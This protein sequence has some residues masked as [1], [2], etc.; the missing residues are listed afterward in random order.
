ME[1][2]NRQLISVII[3]AYNVAPW[4]SRCLDSVAAQTYPYLEIIVVDDGSTDDTPQILDDLAPGCRC[5]RVIHTENQGVTKAR[6]TGVRAAKGA[7][8]G[9]VDGDD[10]I[11]PDM[12]ER[13]MANAQ[14]CHA[15]ISHCGYQ[16]RFPDG[17]IRYYH[18]T[19]VCLQMKRNEALSELLDG[20][21][22]EPGLW[23][24][25]FSR[26]L[27]DNLL[28]GKQ[29]DT[30]VRINEDLLMNYYLFLASKR[31][32][33]DDVCK[34]HYM[35]RQG[36]ASRAR[37]N[38][39]RIMD[40]IRVK[41]IILAQCPQELKDTAMRVY[42]RTCVYSYN[43][44][45]W[46]REYAYLRDRIRGM[47]TERKESFGYLP[48]KQRLMAEMIARAPGV[49]ALIYPIYEKFLQRKKYE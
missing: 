30:S 1:E 29:M 45:L 8:I 6:L 17:R 28:T 47:L 24:K 16:T 9:F 33:F 46:S 5:L 23:N 48:K 36:S 11:E 21:R 39:H 4:I 32:V 2:S 12:Y 20:G 38:E 18:N 44:V 19:G 26:K 27:F 15:D 25:L 10:V 49:Y 41:E 43:A 13:L 35:V 14:R 7:W 37:V 22:I 40:P 31:S 3:P 42:L 34:Y